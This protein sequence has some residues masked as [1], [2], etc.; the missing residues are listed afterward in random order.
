MNLKKPKFWDYNKPNIFAY[1]LYP[2]ALLIKLLSFLNSRKNKKKVKIKTDKIFK[3][4]IVH[5]P[6]HAKYFCVE[7]VSHP[8]DGFNLAYKGIENINYDVLMPYQKIRGSIKI[9]IDNF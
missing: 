2:F 3:H 1:F 7:P 8:T 4:L 6:G 9:E 5:V